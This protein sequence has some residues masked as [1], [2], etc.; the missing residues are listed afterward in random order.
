MTQSQSLGKQSIAFKNAPY[1]HAYT[2]VVGPKEGDGPLKKYF[3][4][5]ASD[6]MFGGSSW[7]EAE[8]GLQAETVKQLLS[9]SG[10]S[11]TDIKYAF[12]GDLLGQ[13]MATSFG[14]SDYNIPLFGIYGACSAFVSVIAIAIP[15]FAASMCL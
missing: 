6:D 1:I 12:A 5:I 4:K 14:L 7:E 11:A 2:S 13:L 8:S 10:V 3:G 9:H 15:G